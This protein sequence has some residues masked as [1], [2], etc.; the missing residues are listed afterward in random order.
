MPMVN[1]SRL[2]R[3]ITAA[4]PWIIN[5]SASGSKTSCENRIVVAATAPKI[6]IVAITNRR[7]TLTHLV[8]FSE[9]WTSTMALED[10]GMVRGSMN[11]SFMNNHRKQIPI[12]YWVPR[13][14]VKIVSWHGGWS[15]SMRERKP[16]QRHAWR[17]GPL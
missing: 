8:E 10:A 9:G 3:A 6:T 17:I 7:S 5:D 13:V 14:D 11:D 1:Q 16:R 4:Q 12:L 15:P 2:G